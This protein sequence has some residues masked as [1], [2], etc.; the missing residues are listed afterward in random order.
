VTIPPGQPFIDVVIN[1][2]D[3]DLF[4]GSETV[5]VTLFDSG[6]YDTGTPSTA[7]VTIADNDPP[8]TLITSS[9]VSAATSTSAHFAFSGSNPT[10]AIAMFE[11]ALDTASF[12]TCSSPIDYDNLP[13]GSHTFAVRAVSKSGPADP[14]PATFMWI[15][16]TTP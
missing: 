8:D 1:P 3:D 12:T 15:V 2:V 14:T 13:D 16:D 5:T 6:S 7:T 9:P 4:E 11:C 10:S